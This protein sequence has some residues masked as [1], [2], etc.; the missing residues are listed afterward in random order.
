MKPDVHYKCKSNLYAIQAVLKYI[1]CISLACWM[2][3]VILT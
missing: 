3:N 1:F 2:R